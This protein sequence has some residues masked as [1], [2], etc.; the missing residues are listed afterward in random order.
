MKLII[1]YLPLH[2]VVAIILLFGPLLSAPLR[3]ER[4]VPEWPAADEKIR[5]IIDTDLANEI[6]DLYALGLVLAAQE[7]FDIEG[8]VA[9]HWGDAGGP[10]GL[11]ESYEL[12]LEC[13]RVAGMEGKIPVLKGSQPFQFSQQI[14]PSPGVDFIVE[15]AMDP[16]DERPLWV[17][18]LGACTNIA[19]AWK[20]EPAI[21]DRVI[22]LWHGRTQ[23]PV[24]CP[25]RRAVDS[26]LRNRWWW[27]SCG[28]CDERRRTRDAWQGADAAQRLG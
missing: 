9:A 5:V 21:K 16:S 3:A 14:I 11:D 15:R 24:K 8:I 26:C 25:P 23:W 22:S 17:I 4:V 12:I 18:S 27:S 20:R 13:M 28:P 10:D 19:M 2:R 6:D 1:S 7:R